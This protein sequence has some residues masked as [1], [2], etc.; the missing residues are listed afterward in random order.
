MV[1]S[2]DDDGEQY[3]YC[4]EQ[5]QVIIEFVVLSALIT[6]SVQEMRESVNSNGWHAGW[7]GP[8]G[9]LEKQA[10]SLQYGGIVLVTIQQ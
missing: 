5:P 2:V 6:A 1:E 10:M 4:G 3:P 7:D 8:E 9:S